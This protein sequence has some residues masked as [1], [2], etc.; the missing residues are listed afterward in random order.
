MKSFVF[1]EIEVRGLSAAQT[2]MDD[3]TASMEFPKGDNEQIV[4]DP[5]AGDEAVW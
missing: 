4:T 2:V 3:I 1:P 5:A